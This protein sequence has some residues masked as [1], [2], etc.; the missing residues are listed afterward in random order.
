[1]SSEFNS[2]QG[3]S[4][5]DVMA[6]LRNSD[7][8]AYDYIFNEFYHALSYFTQKITDNT[9]DAEDIVS[10]TFQTFFAI[11]DNFDTLVNVKAFLYITAR[12]RSF[13]LLRRRQREAANQKDLILAV[14]K[15]G[16]EKS[17]DILQIQA[18]LMRMINKEVETLP[19]KY[20]SVFELSFFADLSNEEIAERLNISVTNVSSIKSRALKKLRMQLLEKG[21]LS[22]YA[23][24]SVIHRIV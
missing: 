23:F 16:E 22:L 3:L 8:R 20:R 2:K 11:K 1:M 19:D 10:Q 17:A 14:G 13:D 6:A 18:E 24:F 12:N 5:H 15:F 9:Q 21:L 7:R 4:E